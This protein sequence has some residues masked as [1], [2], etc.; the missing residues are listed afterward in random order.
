M[1]TLFS[2][3]ECS[4]P[5]G[6]GPVDPREMRQRCNC[7]EPLL[8]RYDLT[9]ARRLPRPGLSGR[10]A[11]MWR[12]RELLPLLTSTRGTDAP[13]TLGEGWTPLIRARRVGAALGLKRL[14]IKDESHNPTSSMRA[15]GMSTAVTRALHAGARGVAAA[16]AGHTTGAAAIYAARAA[17]E[18]RVFTAADA[19]PSYAREAAWHAAITAEPEGSLGD[20]ERLAAR[21]SGAERWVDVSAMAEPY[22]VEGK[23]TIGYELAEQ[24]AWELPDWIVCPAGSGTAFVGIAKALVEMASMGWIDPVRRPHMVAVQ[25]A[26]CAP[27]VRAFAA[28]T[29]TA[30]AWAP[31]RTIADD[32]RVSD[33]P[34]TRLVLRAIRDSGGAALGV[35][36]AEIVRDMRTLAQLEGI[37]AAPGGG[38]AL[39][40][41]R[42]LTSEGRIKPHDAVVIINPGSALPYLDLL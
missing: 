17:L 9:A 14:Y 21:A 41:V 32:L 29:D 19:R 36:D 25:A 4:L 6:A 23:K 40:A 39:H 34:G 35:G 24:L 20:A 27:M 30:E 7:G 3:L 16:G 5:C 31:A 33:P 22:R 1:A 10:E 15:R 8:A 18:T 38:A 26:G 37:S 2:H 42:V 12:Y 13:V 28:G 11:S